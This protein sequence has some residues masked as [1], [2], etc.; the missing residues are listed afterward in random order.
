[1]YRTSAWAG[2]PAVVLGG[3]GGALLIQAIALV[4]GGRDLTAGT[5]AAMIAGVAAGVLL[6]LAVARLGARLGWLGA[7]VAALGAGGIAF[8]LG[9]AL[10]VAGWA[11]GFYLPNWTLF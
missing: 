6:A 11:A 8:L 2:R 9:E 10:L 4:A 5:E 7:L 1:V 3:V